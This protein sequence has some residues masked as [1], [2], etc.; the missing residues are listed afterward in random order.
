MSDSV[1]LTSRLT[2]ADSHSIV[3]LTLNAPKTLNALT[4]QMVAELHQALRSCEA[5][6]SVVAVI[7][8]G[9]GERA[10]CAGG[11]IKNLRELSLNGDQG[12]SFFA[13]EYAL[14]YAIHSFSKPLVVWG[15]GIVMGGGLGLL[16]EAPF[17]VVTTTTRIAMPEITIGLYP[18]VGGSYFLSRAPGKLG[19]FMGLTGCS[20]NGTDAVGVGLA[21][22][23]LDDLQ[24]SELTKAM[25]MLTWEQP[26]Q[27][28]T[29]LLAQL[30]SSAS[31][32]APRLL[33]YREE[34]DSL[35]ASN[36]LSE[37][38]QAL[39]SYQGIDFIESAA[40]K[41]RSGCPLTAC[42]VWEQMH[43]AGEMSLADV[44]RM[45]WWMSVR[46]L[47]QAD[48]AEG[49]RALVIDKD[50]SPNWQHADINE[51]SPSLIES[52]FTCNEAHPL[53]LLGE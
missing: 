16:A 35:C 28:L 4:E 51:V 18:D 37:I 31:S 9:A 41:Y 14:D 50:Q 5:D 42:L 17:R 52:F 53:A 3:E 1:M 48:F 23:R 20:I 26:R 7:I 21:D 2:T 40:K 27:Q 49:V 24:Y 36:D 22:Y 30:A 34:I 8:K 29:E 13:K 33:A 47:Q 46:C 19:L 12:R 25:A 38:D 44:F 15:N 10:L 32:L 39:K 43:R 11:D 6:D 45:E